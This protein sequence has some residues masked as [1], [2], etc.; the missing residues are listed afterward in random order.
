MADGAAAVAMPGRTGGVLA[1]VWGRSVT[2]DAVL[3]VGA[4]ALVGGAAQIAL[5]VPGSPVPVTGQTFAVLVT[6]A[7]LGPAR[8]AASMLL[9]VVAGGLGIPWFA[10]GTS[11]LGGA[12]VGYLVGFVLAAALVGRLAAAGADRRPWR[13][14]GL[15]AAGNAVIYLVGVS[16]LT[17]STGVDLPGALAVGLV[18]FLIGDGLK[19][20]LAAGLL[21]SAWRLRHRL[22]THS[23]DDRGKR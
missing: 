21:P 10:N 2:R 14:L 12:T 8:G 22:S 23:A 11:G 1:D 4:A 6:A 19:A 9:Y 15:M 7:A 18:P 5:P 13:T 3:V 16:W 17:V 20:L